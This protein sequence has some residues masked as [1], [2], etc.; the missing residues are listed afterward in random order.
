MTF[1]VSSLLLFNVR[2]AM[3]LALPQRDEGRHDN[4]RTFHHE[5]RELIADGFSSAGGHQ[6][7]RVLAGKDVSDDVLLQGAERVVTEVCF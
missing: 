6:Y 5:G 3:P 7:D 2:A 4:G 1:S